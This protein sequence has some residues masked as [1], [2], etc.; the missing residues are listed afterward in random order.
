RRADPRGGAK[1]EEAIMTTAAPTQKK[2]A[3]AKPAQTNR[4]NLEMK[5]YKGLDSTLCNGCGHDSITN[6]VIKSFFEYGT[7]P[8][9]VSKLSGM[10]CRSKTTAYFLTRPH[11]LNAVH[12]RMAAIAVGTNLANRNLINIGVSGDGDTASIGLSHYL[13]MVRRNTQIVYIIE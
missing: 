1:G 9:M 8:H 13:H 6:A 10:G 11:G 2:P 4:L 7:E 12:G 5:V 3:G